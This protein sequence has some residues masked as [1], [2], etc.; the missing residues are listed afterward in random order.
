[1]GGKNISIDQNLKAYLQNLKAMKRYM[2]QANNYN[3]F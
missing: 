2:M 1:M 3:R